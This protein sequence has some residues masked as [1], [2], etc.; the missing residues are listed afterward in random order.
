MGVQSQDLRQRGVQVA[1]GTL[2]RRHRRLRL[3]TATVSWTPKKSRMK[4]KLKGFY[5]PIRDR[6]RRVVFTAFFDISRAPPT[7]K[8]VSAEK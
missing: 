5:L 1:V 6:K 4:P 2:R 3:T 8:H 7:A